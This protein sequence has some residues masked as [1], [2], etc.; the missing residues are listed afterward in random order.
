MNAQQYITKMKQFQE[1]LLEY[2]SN[3][4]NSENVVLFM[5]DQ[6]Q[7][8]QID[9][10][11]ATLKLIL[12]IVNNHLRTPCFFTKIENLL[13]NFKKEFQQIFSNYELFDFFKSSKLLLL[14]LSKN[15]Y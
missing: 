4:K 9:E 11:K 13:S 2:F 6:F 8:N 12:E 1:D 14:F 10:I 5:K 15:R 3:D 7:Q